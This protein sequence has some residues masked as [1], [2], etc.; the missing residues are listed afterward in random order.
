[1][2]DVARL[3]GREDHREVDVG[4]G[5]N[6]LVGEDGLCGAGGVVTALLDRHHADTAHGFGVPTRGVCSMPP[7]ISPVSQRSSFVMSAS[8]KPSRMVKARVPPF[9]AASNPWASMSG[10]SA[11]RPVLRTSGL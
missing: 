4:D 2:R 6:R 8:L 11:E 3:V 7:S 10:W 1:M 5:F 9:S